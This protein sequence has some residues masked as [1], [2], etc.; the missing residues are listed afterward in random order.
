MD[1]KYL[2]TL[3]TIL[4]TGSFQ[5]AALWLNYTQSTVTFH[6][7]QLE[8][9]F[10]I[11]LF[12]KIGRKM[13][14]TQAGQEIL[15]HVETILKEMEQIQNYGKDLS[16]MTGTLRI[17]MPD[18]LLCYKM[19]PLMKSFKQKA[20]NVQLIMQAL[21]CYAIREGV[22]QGSVDMGIHCDI[23]GY[24]SSVIAEP[25]TAY[26]AVLVASAEAD[27][28]Q[29]DFITPHQRKKWNLLNSDPHSLHQRRLT[30]YLAEKDILMNGDIE[31]WSVEAVKSS[32]LGGLGIAYLPDFTITKELKEGSLVQVKTELDQTPVPVVCAYHKNKW[33]SPAMELFQNLLRQG[34]SGTQE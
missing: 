7:Q 11:Q 29:L 33:V 3:K 5:K 10:S 23:G 25:L 30:E 8:Q 27:T 28:R 9:A 21:H 4:E 12:E 20:P 24:P 22:I 31:L 14:L 26:H 16:V 17:G 13:V 19:Q 1:I 2:Q 15:P 18:A 6:V 32:V 34:I